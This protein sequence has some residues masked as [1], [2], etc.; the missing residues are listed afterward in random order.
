MYSIMSSASS[1]SLTF[2]FPIRIIFISFLFLFSFLI[3]MSRNLNHMLNTSFKS[4]YPCLVSHLRGNIVSF[5]LLIIM[6]A[7]GLSYMAFILLRY[8]PSMPTFWEVFYYKWILNFIKSF[9]LH[10]LRWYRFF[11][12]FVNVVYHIDWFVNI[13]NPWISGI[14]PTW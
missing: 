6:L 11:L 1:D 4:R 7:V 12:Q 13:E 3:A 9:F 14:N 5:S 2:S 10:L 8:I